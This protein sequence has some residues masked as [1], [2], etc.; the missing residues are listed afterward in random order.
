MESVQSNHPF[1]CRRLVQSTVLVL[2]CLWILLPGIA[3]AMFRCAYCSAEFHTKGDLHSHMNRLHPTTRPT[4]RLSAGVDPDTGQ[5]S[6]QASRPGV[7]QVESGIRRR[8]EGGEFPLID[9][10]IKKFSTELGGR[11]PGGGRGAP[12]QAE[13]QP[14]PQTPKPPPGPRPGDVTV[15][16]NNGA[17]FV[18]R[19]QSRSGQTIILNT[20]EGAQLGF[21]LDQIKEIRVPKG[22]LP[23]RSGSAG[24]RRRPVR[25]RR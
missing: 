8:T 10:L 3:L 13:A 17:E 1:C 6:L 23:V 18:G 24:P 19:I 16:L 7:D 21:Q 25:R 15:V 9:Q 14:E 4:L 22:I 2:L 5:V 11:R 12:A 20:V